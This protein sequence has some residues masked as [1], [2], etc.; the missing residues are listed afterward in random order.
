M[1]TGLHVRYPL[2]LPY[3]SETWISRQILEKQKNK[4]CP[5]GTELFHM[6]RRTDG[7]TDKQMTKLIVTFHNIANASKKLFFQ[8]IL[9]HS[10]QIASWN[11]LN[12]LVNKPRGWH[13][14]EHGSTPIKGKEY[15][16][17]SLHTLT[18]RLWAHPASYL[19]GP[20]SLGQSKQRVKLTDHP[21]P[22][23]R[24]KTPG[25]LPPHL[26]TW[27]INKDRYKFTSFFNLYF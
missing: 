25:A 7:R 26:S 24:L 15:S 20:T 22:D 21:H 17:F 10:A 13:R 23:H 5:V 1:Q 18:A 12:C 19:T 27:C 14:R 6:D 3:F 11:I 4:I 2:F 8:I 9:C 16:Y